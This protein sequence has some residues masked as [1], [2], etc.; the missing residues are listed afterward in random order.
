M[1]ACTVY[2]TSALPIIFVFFWLDF[3]VNM[4][5]LVKFDLLYLFLSFFLSSFF[6]DADLSLW[7]TFGRQP[8]RKPS[9]KSSIPRGKRQTWCPRLPRSLIQKMKKGHQEMLSHYRVCRR[10][11]QVGR[12]LF[13]FK[14][15]NQ[16]YATYS[17]TFFATI[18]MVC[19]GRSGKTTQHKLTVLHGI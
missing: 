9:L 7:A 4:C 19:D 8:T 15:W 2:T 14:D 6:L 5:Y 10:T 12:S 11:F 3:E 16:T 1:H 13:I 18:K 17:W